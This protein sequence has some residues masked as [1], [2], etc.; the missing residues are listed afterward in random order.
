MLIIFFVE[1]YLKRDTLTIEDLKPPKG[2]FEIGIWSLGW[3]GWLRE[4]TADFPTHCDVADAPFFL[5]VYSA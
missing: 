3:V 5:T 2:A 1:D 4:L